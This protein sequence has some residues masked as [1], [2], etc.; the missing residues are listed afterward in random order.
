MQVTQQ[1]N[2]FLRIQSAL[3][4]TNYLFTAQLHTI[5]GDLMC[6]HSCPEPDYR[7]LGNHSHL[8]C[9]LRPPLNT[10]LHSY[11]AMQV[12]CPAWGHNCTRYGGL[13]VDMPKR[14][15]FLRYT[16]TMQFIVFTFNKKKYI[17]LEPSP[18]P[19]SIERVIWLSCMH[20]IPVERF[21]IN[22]MASWEMSHILPHLLLASLD[23]SRTNGLT[24]LQYLLPSPLFFF[25]SWFPRSLRFLLCRYVCRGSSTC[26]LP[27]G[28][29]IC[30]QMI[31]ALAAQ[32]LGL[33]CVKRLVRRITRTHCIWK[34]EEINE[35][36]TE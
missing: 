13:G 20:F 6:S 30:M 27:K 16:Q 19:W 2:L 22:S 21:P 5:G 29:Y 25:P 15:G 12:K 4:C 32:A 7:K 10:D 31:A 1:S 17:K 35:S 26:K 11:E 23:T 8:K 36:M 14:C 34:K 28:E 3:L 18:C 9:P 24:G 33:N